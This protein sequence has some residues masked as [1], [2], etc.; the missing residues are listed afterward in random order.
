M[1][2][3]MYIVW[4]VS[5]GLSDLHVHVHVDLCVFYFLALDYLYFCPILP[6]AIE[7]AERQLCFLCTCTLSVSLPCL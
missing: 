5:V 7:E 2:M 3:Y 1:Y 6:V 4:V